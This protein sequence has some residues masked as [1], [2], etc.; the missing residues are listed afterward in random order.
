[1][2]AEVKE[3]IMVGEELSEYF[4]EDIKCF[5]PKHSS[6]E[7]IGANLRVALGRCLG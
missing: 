5:C 4:P 7:D 3:F 1:M 2:K 6:N